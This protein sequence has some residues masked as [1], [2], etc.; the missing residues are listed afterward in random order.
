MK[1]PFRFGTIVQDDAFTDRVVEQQTVK[2]VI[3]SKNHLIIISAR[4]YGKSSLIHKTLSSISRPAILLDLQLVSDP[5]DFATQLLKKTFEKY[6]IEKI[7][8]HLTHFRVIPNVS[9][10]P[11]TNAINISFQP[12]IDSLVAL[13]EVLNLIDK[14]GEKGEKPIVVLDEFQ[15]ILNID[16]HLDKKLRAIMQLHQ[17]VNYVFLGSAESM[18]H[19]IFEK[20]KS[21]FYHFGFIM[22]LQKIAYEDFYAFLKDKF[23]CFTIDTDKLTNDI[24]TLTQCHPY[25]TQQIAFQCWNNAEKNILEEQIFLQSFNEV[26]HFHDNDYER[27]WNTLNQTDKKVVTALAENTLKLIDNPTSTIYSSLTRLTK[28]G[29]LIKDKSYTID[30]PFFKAWI[31]TKRNQ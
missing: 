15:E 1:N 23:S 17:N 6:K 30:D 11:L 29:F 31:I 24:L 5:T 26:L 4:R 10:N 20:K 16:S 8:H 27:L 9:L 13:E 28:Q 22:T 21:P 18:M 2:E 14:I 7:K 3:Q 12:N 19:E 25:Y